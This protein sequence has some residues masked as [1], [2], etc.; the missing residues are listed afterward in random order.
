M[1]PWWGPRVWQKWIRAL[2]AWPALTAPPSP[3]FLCL[4]LESSAAL[5]PELGL[6]TSTHCTDSVMEKNPNSSTSTK[7]PPRS[8]STGP[9]PGETKTKTGDRRLV[10]TPWMCRLAATRLAAGPA[11]PPLIC[12]LTSLSKHLTCWAAEL[13]SVT[14]AVCIYTPHSSSNCHI[15]HKYIRT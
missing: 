15:L 7:V 2:A 5:C 11:G 9:A 14:P 3:A 4:M 8:S 6:N 1:S 10:W 13:Q 12:G